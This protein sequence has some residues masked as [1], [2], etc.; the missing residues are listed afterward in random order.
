MMLITAVLEPSRVD[1]VKAALRLFDVQGLTASRVFV[2]SRPGR[3][4]IY[5]GERWVVSM[6][7]RIRLDI[8]ASNDDTADL[9]RVIVRA[10]DGGEGLLWLTRVD[11]VV[12]IRTGEWGLP[13]L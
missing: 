12:R 3:V 6:V 4:E 10:A 5:R 9:V 2:P 8:L 11:H 1:T 13:A 7:P